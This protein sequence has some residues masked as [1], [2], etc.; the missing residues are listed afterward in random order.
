M[1]DRINELEDAARTLGEKGLVHS[2]ALLIWAIDEITTLRK[3]LSR[4]S[5]SEYAEGRVVD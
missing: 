3:R 4:E 1:S 2:E 5:R